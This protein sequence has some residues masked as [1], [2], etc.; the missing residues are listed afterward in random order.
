MKCVKCGGTVRVVGHTHRYVESGLPNVILHGVDVRKC[1][2]CSEEEVAIPNV[3]GLHNS[4]AGMIVGR[5]SAMTR[6]EFRFLRQ[7]LGRSSQEFAKLIDV[8][9]ETVSRWQTGQHEI[10]RSVDLLVRLL[11]TRT[12]AR[13]DYTDEIIEKMRPQPARAPRLALRLQGDRWQAEKA[14]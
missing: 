13:I 3:T 6:E 4:L 10:P 7:F 1:S 9:A 11:V 14:A 2:K 5:R 12:E 8:S